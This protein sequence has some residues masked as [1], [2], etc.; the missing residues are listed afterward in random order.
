MF[1]NIKMHLCLS[2][3][4]RVVSV[5]LKKK[6]ITELQQFLLC[7]ALQTLDLNTQ[8]YSMNH[9]ICHV[10]SAFQDTTQLWS[11]SAQESR[12]LDIIIVDISTINLDN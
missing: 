12:A 6:L 8:Q 4:G 5:N 2:I 1:M 9:K 7:H 11:G 3:F 10:S